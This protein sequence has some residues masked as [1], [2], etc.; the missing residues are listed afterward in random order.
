MTEEIY[1]SLKIKN[2]EKEFVDLMIYPI[3]GE[4]EQYLSGG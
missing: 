3:Q 1:A 4:N 2:N